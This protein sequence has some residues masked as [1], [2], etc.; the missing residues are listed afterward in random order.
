MFAAG[1]E[2]DP[3][4]IVTHRC[5]CCNQQIELLDLTGVS[6]LWSG[7]Y[8]TIQGVGRPSYLCHH[9][10]IDLV[11]GDERT[12]L[13]S[14]FARFLAMRDRAGLPSGVSL[15]L[16]NARGRPDTLL[17]KAFHLVLLGVQVRN[18]EDSSPIPYVRMTSPDDQPPIEFVFPQ[19][20]IGREGIAAAL[21]CRWSTNDRHSSATA[22]EIVGWQGKAQLSDLH[23]LL[24]GLAL[25]RDFPPKG[26][27]RPKDVSR[28]IPPEVFAAELPKV[29]REHLENF[30]HHPTNSELASTFCV[31][32]STL[33]R[34]LRR[35]RADGGMWPPA[36]RF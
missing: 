25:L 12:A 2:Q 36:S 34:W 14:F 7:R 11:A 26:L 13:S 35:Y 3:T 4:V 24:D 32:V 23:A 1:E 8:S 17:G 22:L 19:I 28:T 30:S 5:E 18:W 33:E 29:Y 27:G 9:C 21:E 6:V 20:A 31:S 15:H 10:R 16:L